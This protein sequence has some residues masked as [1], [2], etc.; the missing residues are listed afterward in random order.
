MVDPLPRA[1]TQLG[2]DVAADDLEPRLQADLRDPG[3]HGAE[4]DDADA[5]DLHGARSYG[6]TRSI[7]AAIAWPNPMHI[8][9]TP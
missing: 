7:T 5:S 6:F 2:A 9:A 3:A 4:A 1:L 8:V